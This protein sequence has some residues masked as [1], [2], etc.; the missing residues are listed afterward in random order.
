MQALAVLAPPVLAWLPVPQATCVA[1]EAHPFRLQLLGLVQLLP[2]LTHV[3][4]EVRR[5]VALVLVVLAVEASPAGALVP[6][7]CPYQL[8]ELLP[9]LA[10][11]MMASRQA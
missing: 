10:P 6:S 7:L 9:A 2:A 11:Q 5:R 4:E 8:V 3:Q 1:S